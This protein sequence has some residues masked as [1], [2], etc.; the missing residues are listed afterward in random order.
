[1]ERQIILERNPRPG[2]YQEEDVRWILRENSARKCRLLHLYSKNQE[3][4]I[5]A[6]STQSHLKMQTLFEYDYIPEDPQD[7]QIEII[8][9]NHFFYYQG[10]LY[11]LFLKENG[12]LVVG[13][14]GVN[15]SWEEV[16]FIAETLG[17]KNAE[18][19]I[20]KVFKLQE[21]R[22]Q[23][24]A[25]IGYC[26][27]ALNDDIMATLPLF[28]DDFV[29]I[30]QFSYQELDFEWMEAGERVFHNGEVWQVCQDLQK[31]FFLKQ[32]PF[33]VKK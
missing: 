13:E 9:P 31:H 26:W 11:Y 12:R 5:W 19:Q 20:S 6:I 33:F 2:V 4:Y 16:S 17:V 14:I 3:H 23:A 10:N 1:M 22:L 28:K 18:F 8:L 15:H 27:R 24:R 7:F 30:R 21:N 25:L 29:K 32:T